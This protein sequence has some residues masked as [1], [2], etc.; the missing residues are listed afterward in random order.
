VQAYGS[1]KSRIQIM[2]SHLRRDL[3]SKFQARPVENHRNLQPGLTYIGTSGAWHQAST[4]HNGN[5]GSIHH[6]PIVEALHQLA[7]LLI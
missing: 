2:Q 7:Q 5:N 3:Y 6:A 4:A 1:K